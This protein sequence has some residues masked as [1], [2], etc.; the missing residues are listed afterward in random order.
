MSIQVRICILSGIT[1]I[2]NKK[3]VHNYSKEKRRQLMNFDSLSYTSS[4]N[5]ANLKKKNR[6]SLMSLSFDLSTSSPTVS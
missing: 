2:K 4:R 1:T 6:K 3:F 5:L